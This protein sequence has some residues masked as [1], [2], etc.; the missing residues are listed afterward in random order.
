M[1]ILMLSWRDMK[2]P[3][4]GG[5]E[6]VTDIYIK[7]L[8]RLGHE[9]TLF[10]AEYENCKEQEDYNNYRIIRKGDQL[11]VHFYGLLYAKKKENDFDL[12]IDQINT[13]PFFT[14]L[15]IKKE[16]RRAFFH[17][18]CKNIW[19]Y[20]SRFPI[21]ILGY[22]LESIYLKFYKN[23]K[24]FVVSDSTKK[25][26]MKY[27][28][29][30][31]ENI[32]VLDNHID[33][34]PIMKISYKQDYF[35]FCGRLTK[36]KRVHDAIKAMRLFLDLNNKYNE[37]NNNK[38]IIQSTDQK[39][40]LSNIN[41]K[42]YIIGNGNEKYKHKLNTLIKKLNLKDR[43]IFT[44]NITNNERN[45]LMQKA[46]AILVTSVREGWGLIVTEANA[47]GTI[48]ITYKTH[49]L[50]DANNNH[51]GIITEDNTPQNLAKHMDF[52]IEN[53]K[54][55]KQKERNALKNAREHSDWSRNVMALEEWLRT[56]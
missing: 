39:F 6:I 18:L 38:D 53:P 31:D 56:P 10:S 26:L 55:R 30:K 21:S 51:T 4:K 16:K 41:F 5:A 43:V 12:I 3:Q 22:M 48:A 50:V 47:N 23:T 17:Q 45:K 2:S 42:L 29:I 14:P 13:I 35:I 37:V 52:I 8:V 46:L 49:G 40:R 15:F 19:F 1:K 28:K 36:S 25:D 44:N 9:V 32:L 34:K 20:E 7:G 24:A 27:A 11:T 54:I 33:F